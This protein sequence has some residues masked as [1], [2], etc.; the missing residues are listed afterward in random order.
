[1]GLATMWETLLA[2]RLLDRLGASKYPSQRDGLSPPQVVRNRSRE[3][4]DNVLRGLVKAVHEADDAAAGVQH[5]PQ[6]DRQ[7]RIS[8]SVEMSAKRLDNASSNVS[9]ERPAK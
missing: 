8:I 7:H 4:L 9:R 6:K 3:A 2:P 5:L 1:M